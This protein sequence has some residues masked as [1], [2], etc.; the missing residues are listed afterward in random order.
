MLDI[1]FIREN[2][3]VVRAAIKNKKSAPVDLDELFK[4]ADERKAVLQAVDD[5]NRK[6]NEAAKAR[7]VEAGKQLK[8][9][10]QALEE[11]KNALDKQYVQEMIKLPNIPTADTPV[12]ADDSGNKITREWGDKPHFDYKPKEHAELGVALGIINSEKAA[13][14]SG[15]RFTYLMGD[16][17][18]LHWALM[19][20]A[21]SVL[22]SEERLKSIAEAEGLDVSHKPFIPVLPPVMIKKPVQ[23]RM[24][25][26]LTDP[27]HYL[28]PEEDMML[29]GSAEHT[30][31]P[32]HMDEVLD[33]KDLPIRYVGYSTA[34]RREAGTY[35]KDTSGIIRLH[36]F[37]KLEMEAF[38]V[39]EKGMVEQD[40]MVAIQEYLMRSLKLPHQRILVCTGDMGF[41]DQRQVDIET[42]FPG[43]GKFRETHSADYVG[44]FQARRLNTRVKRAGGIEHVHMNDATVMSQ[45]PLAAILENYQE[46][47]GSIRIPDVLV[48]Y[49]GKDVIKKT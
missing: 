19:Q 3:D 29:I 16:L 34:F 5:L 35:G 17:V 2:A 48:P 40:F 25:R 49:M 9:E 41:P 23:V 13:E 8:D 21:L 10:L 42:W 33:E 31:G 46:A 1:K 30:L 12:G 6:R 22:S 32:L 7:D 20:Y 45:R 4:L 38:T 24:A 27:D 18:R 26:Y 11:R 14:V 39:P 37:E 44:G 28:F 43:Q 36:Q 47:D 15:S